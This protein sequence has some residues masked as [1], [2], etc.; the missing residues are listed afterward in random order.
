MGKLIRSSLQ[1]R[2]RKAQLTPM[3]GKEE[4]VACCT[5]AACPLFAFSALMAGHGGGSGVLA[6]AFGAVAGGTGSDEESGFDIFIF[7]PYL[8]V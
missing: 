7:I 3:L 2:S 8:R 5:G 1:M 4:T 6:V